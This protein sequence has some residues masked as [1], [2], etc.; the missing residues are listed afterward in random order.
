MLVGF[1]RV[2][3]AAGYPLVY[4]IDASFPTREPELDAF[5]TRYD[6]SMFPIAHAATSVLETISIITAVD[7]FD[8]DAME[9]L[10]PTMV[11]S[12]AR[13]MMTCSSV[14]GWYQSDERRDLCVVFHIDSEQEL[15]T[16]HGTCDR[17]SEQSRLRCQ[18]RQW[19][20]IDLKGP[21]SS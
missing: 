5:R 17:Q 4:V 12:R 21:I 20:R 10:E 16:R 9:M 6:F 7:L 3:A 14:K 8:R 19:R 2:V 13:S 18:R 15:A 1:L 11:N